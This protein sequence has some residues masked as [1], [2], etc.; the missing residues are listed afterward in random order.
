MNHQILAQYYNENGDTVRF[1][2]FTGSMEN[3]LIRTADFENELV[4]YHVHRY[5]SINEQMYSEDVTNELLLI[6][7]LYRYVKNRS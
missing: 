1:E 2:A 5:D 7:R 4:R 6:Q 3:I